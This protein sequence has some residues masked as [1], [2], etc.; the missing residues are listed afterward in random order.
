M[1]EA[2][3]SNIYVSD[4]MLAEKHH[5]AEIRFNLNQ[6][7]LSK[8][9]IRINFSNIISEFT[10]INEQ[11]RYYIFLINFPTCCNFLD[12]LT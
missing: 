9:D 11:F 6:L 2:F 3:I 7:I 4:N 8:E 10:S 5:R 12:K 1:A